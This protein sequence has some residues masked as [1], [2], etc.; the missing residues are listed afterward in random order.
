MVPGDAFYLNVIDSHRYFVLH[1]SVN[2]SHKVLVFNFTTHRP[3][4]CDETCIVLPSE[5]S[6]IAHNSVVMYSQGRLMEDPV[7]SNF[8]AAIGAAL[9]PIGNDIL[10]RIKAG[11]LT[12]IHTPKKIKTFLLQQ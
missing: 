9:P 6:G 8:K 2:P 11:A 10:L 1:S 5:Y 3:G 12:S 7:L 4:Q